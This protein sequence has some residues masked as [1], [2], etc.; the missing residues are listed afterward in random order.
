ME[1][2]GSRIWDK[3]VRRMLHALR[4]SVAAAAVTAA[5]VAAFV[6]VM[7]APEAAISRSFATALG[8]K[9]SGEAAGF[10]PAHL[11]LSSMPVPLEPA[12]AGLPSHVSVGDRITFSGRASGSRSYRITS[13]S[14][15]SVGEQVAGGAEPGRLLLVTAEAVDGNAPATMRFVIEASNGPR[16]VSGP[17]KPRS[18]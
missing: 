6:A 8:S 5:S 13:V 17:S 14:P 18:L 10:D 7:S 16:P 15:F 11:H 9:G 12:A 4:I 2:V 3:V 1:H